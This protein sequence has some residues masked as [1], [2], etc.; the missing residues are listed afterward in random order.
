MKMRTGPLAL[1]LIVGT[2]GCYGVNSR[3]LETP[4]PPTDLYRCLQIELG[5]AGYGIVGADRAS[6]WLHAQRRVERL[7]DVVTAEVYATVIPD[8]G[9]GSHLQISDNSYARDDAEHILHMC[10]PDGV[11]RTEPKQDGSR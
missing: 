8:Q 10:A 11:T 1:L 2:T 5:R 9:D 7:V 6:G 4:H 3:L